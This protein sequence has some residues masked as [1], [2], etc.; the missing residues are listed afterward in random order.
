MP[1]ASAEARQRRNEYKAAEM[2]LLGRNLSPA[3]IL[4]SLEKPA[5]ERSELFESFAP[6]VAGGPQQ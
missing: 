5:A 4:R 6:L 2:A 3:K 1:L